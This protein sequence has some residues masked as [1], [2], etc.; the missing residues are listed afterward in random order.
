MPTLELV[1]R[2][3]DPASLLL[4]SCALLVMLVQDDE[5][6]EDV[7]LLELVMQNNDPVGIVEL[8]VRG[9]SVITKVGN[10]W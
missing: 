6:E 3:N 5:E 10:G 9:F 8:L 1:M 4:A 7:A 2:T